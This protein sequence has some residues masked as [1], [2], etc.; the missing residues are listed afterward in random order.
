MYSFPL[1]LITGYW[2]QRPVLCS[3]TL[4]FIPFMYYSLHLLTPNSHS[5]LPQP[6]SPLAT[7]HWFSM[8][9]S[10]SFSQICWFVSYFRF[11]TNKCYHMVFVWLTSLRM[12]ISRS[13]HVLKICPRFFFF[14]AAPP[15]SQRLHWV[16][17]PLNHNG[18]CPSYVLN[19]RPRMR[20]QVSLL[21]FH[22]EHCCTAESVLRYFY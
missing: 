21:A 7:T 12:R 19:K 5:L 18:N 8:F 14:M 10:L 6:L 2:M 16:L 11:P 22:T 15:P 9:R 3:R 4:L 1:R 13:I 17:N 20:G